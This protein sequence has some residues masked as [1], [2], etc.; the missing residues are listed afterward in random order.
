LPVEGLISNGQYVAGKKEKAQV[1]IYLRR[2]HPEE[3]LRLLA[4]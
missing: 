3:E 2:G 1:C 4:A